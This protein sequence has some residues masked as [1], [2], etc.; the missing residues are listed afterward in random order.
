MDEKLYIIDS[1]SPFFLKTSKS[2]V[3]WSKVPFDS[4][5][6]KR[7]T[8]NKKFK[9]I[10]DRIRS[11]FENISALGYNAVSIDDLAHLTVFNFY[12]R[13]LK[14]KIAI[15]RKYYKKIFSIANQYGLKVFINSDIMFY[16]R[17]IK[18]YLQKK[19][20]KETVL[21]KKAIS[22]LFKDFKHVSG[23]N[24]RIGESDGVD[25][26]GKF[27]SNVII[28]TP[29]QLNTLIKALIPVCN[30]AQ[31]YCIVRTW[32][33]GAYKVGDLAWNVKTFNVAFKDIIYE[34]FI[35]SMKYADA[36]FFRYLPLNDLFFNTKCKKI[37][38]LQ[39]RREYEG[40]GTFPSYVGYDYYDMYKKLESNTT[41]A[42][43]HV[44]CQTGGWSGF[45]NRTFLKKSSIW[46]EINTVA[47]IKIFKDALNSTEVI[48]YIARDYLKIYDYRKFESFLLL[49]ED[50]IKNLLYDPGFASQS[51]YF[52]KLRIPPLLY[53]FWD[54]VV[55]NRFIVLFFRFFNKNQ[56]NTIIQGEKALHSI[57]SMGR[58]AKELHLDYDV[59]FQYYTCKI[60]LYARKL[61][62]GG[63]NV[64]ISLQLKRMIQKYRDRYP[65][66]YTF[67]ID[68]NA[69]EKRTFF[70]PFFKFFV[71]NKK[72]FRKI[73]YFLFN[74]ISKK[75]ILL[76][77]K[78]FKKQ[79][80]G[81]AG[82]RGMSPEFFLK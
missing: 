11:Y 20:L 27:R 64:V 15:Y 49:S 8:I 33:M 63:N 13:T 47:V 37:I 66:G 16:N 65:F 36:D 40:H 46:N 12:S 81:I 29:E 67:R 75:I 71:R 52:N 6:G 50:V 39:S 28:K 72:E 61:L 48:K 51:L 18:L 55:I 57:I 31:K 34:K 24:L 80:S 14:I 58:I 21:L 45:V 78:L 54:T 3:N 70:N 79:L 74:S 43:I 17:Y 77:V 82:N 56:A 62:Y 9:K 30:E 32:T 42:G 38:E 68:F 19:R 60:I 1:L 26:K 73:D 22:D 2:I 44:W 7:K 10:V 4:L 76:V 41:I 69:F 5:E 23:V 59:K 53:I 35:V 25:V